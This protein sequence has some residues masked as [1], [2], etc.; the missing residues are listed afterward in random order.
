MKLTLL[1]S[2]IG[3]VAAWG[4]LGIPHANP[5]LL[6][7][8]HAQ[9]GPVSEP[10]AERSGDGALNYTETSKSAINALNA[11]YD[12][13]QGRWSP[14]TAWWI[15]GVALQGVLDYTVKTGS[16]E[17]LEQACYIIDKQKG[18]LPWWPDG[19]GLFR[20]DS[21]DD[22][23]WWALALVRMF[24]ITGDSWYLDTAKADEKYMYQ[25]WT[26]NKCGG[27]LV[28]SI[29]YDTYKNAISNQLYTLL[30]ASLHNSI[31]GDTE[32]LAKS[33]AAWEW[34]FGSGMF[35]EDHLFNDGLSNDCISNNQTTWTYNQGV[36]L[37]A[38]TELY[39]ATLNSTYLTVARGIA[40]AVIASPSLVHDGILVEPCE[41][42]CNDDQKTFKGIFARYLAHLS[43]ACENDPYRQFLEDN[44][45]TALKRAHNTTTGLF[46]LSWA[47]PL[48]N[49]SLG[50]Q[51]SALGL[52]VA[53]I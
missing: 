30:T 2:A 1:T 21:T 27:G 43:S 46:D 39:R 23:A 15:S 48:A 31:P 18:S 13:G 10:H 36:I 35:N 9:V 50:T 47:G 4:A 28:Q 6:S 5:E 42:T 29:R 11:L 22:T 49:G 3:L 26:D 44:A 25:Y 41:P 52:F 19:D 38:A 32:Y 51:A 34:L 7:G 40:D 8:Q 53:L 12:D 14:A 24:D 33:K 17:Y 16:Y 20:A 37:G 45:K